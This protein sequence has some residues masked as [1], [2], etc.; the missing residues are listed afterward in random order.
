MNEQELQEYVKNV[1]FEELKNIA[2]DHHHLPANVEIG[3]SNVQ[4]QYH[5]LA[6]VEIGI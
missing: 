5:L 6:N 1:T 3:I 2:Q 4:N